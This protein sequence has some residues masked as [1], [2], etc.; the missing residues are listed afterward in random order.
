MKK[1]HFIAL[2]MAGLLAGCAT[3]NTPDIVTHYDQFTGFRTDMIPENLLDDPNN[4]RDMVWL[5]ASRIFKDFKNFDYYLEVHYKARAEAG[6]LDITPGPSLVVIADGKE[7]KFRGS[8]SLNTRKHRGDIIS[9]DA[10][11]EVSPN[12]LRAIANAQ[13]VKVKVTGRN[14]I[15][16]RDFAP[17]NFQKFKKFVTQDVDAGG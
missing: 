8:G 16:E 7:M 6:L 14:G 3:S 13:A 2:A 17:I 10:L 15:A 9:E 5:N 1:Y 4:N 12:E 11:Y